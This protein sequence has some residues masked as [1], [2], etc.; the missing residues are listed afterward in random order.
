MDKKKKAYDLAEIKIVA[1]E[2]TDVI[3][4]SDDNVDDD[5][6]TKTERSTNNSW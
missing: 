4:T 3:T 6:W 1:I 2:A 5:G